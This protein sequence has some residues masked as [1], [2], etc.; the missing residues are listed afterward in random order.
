[1][2]M[3]ECYVHIV[4]RAFPPLTQLRRGG[5][6]SGKSNLIRSN[7]IKF[8]FLS[9]GRRYGAVRFFPFSPMLCVC[10][11]KSSDRDSSS[12]K[13]KFDSVSVRTKVLGVCVCALFGKYSSHLARCNV[14]KSLGEELL[15]AFA[16]ARRRLRRRRT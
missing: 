9:R 4:P 6:N 1:M 14:I 10:L 3:L 8:I 2:M 13:I 11:C 5:G 7:R 15:M 12:N 16:K